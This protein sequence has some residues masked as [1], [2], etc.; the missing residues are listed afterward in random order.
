MVPIGE[1]MA[2]HREDVGGATLLERSGFL[3]SR[4]EEGRET[5]YE[6]S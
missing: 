6:H 1:G 5:L 2:R 4:E 3:S